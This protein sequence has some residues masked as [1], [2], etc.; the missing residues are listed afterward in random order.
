MRLHSYWEILVVVPIIGATFPSF[1]RALEAPLK[2]RL[3]SDDERNLWRARSQLLDERKQLVDDLCSIVTDEKMQGNNIPAVVNAINLLGD[4]R[5]AQAT[6]YLLKM[7]R[8]DRL[9]GMSDP[10]AAVFRI[11]GPA[12]VDPDSMSKENPCVGALINIRIPPTELIPEM[13]RNGVYCEYYLAV[14]LGTQGKFVATAILKA[15]L[16]KAVSRL[17]ATDREIER[18]FKAQRPVRTM[19]DNLRAKLGFE[20]VLSLVEEY[21]EPDSRPRPGEKPERRSRGVP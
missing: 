21:K 18:Q 14:L 20:H 8:F 19:S 13:M 15:E 12:T 10:S 1:C 3:R 16:E 17:T 5:A 7:I 2:E 4:L 11:P 6:P 9:R